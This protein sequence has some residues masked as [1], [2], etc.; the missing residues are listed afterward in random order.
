RRRYWMAAMALALIFLL[1][2]T[3]A[4]YASPRSIGDQL[5]GM[6]IQ[7]TGTPTDTPTSAPTST[8][9]PTHQLTRPQP[10]TFTSSTT[11]TSTR[12]LT[13]ARPPPALASNPYGKNSRAAHWV[14]LLQVARRVGAR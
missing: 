4:T 11:S 6:G 10:T 13:R 12:T 8:S 7:Q 3:G 9:R 14:S 2:L 5:L 1:L